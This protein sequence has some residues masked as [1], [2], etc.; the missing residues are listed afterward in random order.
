MAAVSPGTDGGSRGGEAEVRVAAPE[1]IDALAFAA[2]AESEAALTEGLSH[3][4]NA[5]VWD[6]GLRAG[7]E[8]LSQGRGAA[9]VFVDLD[10]EAYPAGA[11][12]ELAAV[13]EADTAVVAFGADASAAH[14][15]EVLFAGVGEYL[16]KPLSAAAVREAAARVT[17]GAPGAPQGRLVGFA[18]TGGTG[19]TTLAALTALAAAARGRYVS[20]LDLSRTCAPLALVLDV[21]PASGL[22]DLLGT[23]ARASLNPEMVERVGVSRSPRLVVYAYAQSAGA[24]PPLAPAWAVCELL[25]ELQRRSHLVIVDGVD[26]PELTHA[27]LALVDARVFVVEPTATGAALAAASLARLAPILGAGWPSV[28]VQNHTRAFG[29]EAG[30][31]ALAR[32]GLRTRPQAA[33]PFEPALPAFADRGMPDGR[34][35]KALRA[36]VAALLDRVLFPAGAKATGAPSPTPSPAGAAAPR[37]RTR[38]RSLRAALRGLLPPIAGRL[39]PARRGA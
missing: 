37:G 34:I 9:L 13:C 18:G 27:L 7:L 33:V 23:A 14:C 6:G 16:T 19:T 35:P 2:D 32:A 3:L 5:L 8:V 12:N 11:L 36:P 20:V 4:G 38:R 21:E 1:V 15:R 29:V 10:G 39:R 26:N 30:A 22:V 24:V 28:L 25:V 31:R 17:A